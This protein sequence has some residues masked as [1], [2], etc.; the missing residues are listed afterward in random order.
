MSSPK[1]IVV[2]KTFEEGE[3][4]EIEETLKMTPEERIEKAVNLILQVYNTS[5]EELRSR[6][7]SRRITI[8][9]DI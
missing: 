4:M 6:P 7:R 5:R 8:I 2:Y 9:R 3:A 1:K